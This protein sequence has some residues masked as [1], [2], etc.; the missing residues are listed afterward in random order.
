MAT[1]KT[2]ETDNRWNFLDNQI[3]EYLKEKQEK[4]KQIGNSWEF[5]EQIYPHYNKIDNINY[6]RI[7]FIRDIKPIFMVCKYFLFFIFFFFDEFCYK[8][9]INPEI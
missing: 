9:K 6:K 5:V 8:H 3:K 1:I 7:D 4:V 2:N